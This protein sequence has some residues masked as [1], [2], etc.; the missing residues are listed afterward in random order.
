MDKFYTYLWLREDGTPYYVG[1]GKGKRAYNPENPKVKPPEN[2]ER[3]IIKYWKSEEESFDAEKDLILKYG[4][5]DL[6]TGC[7][8]N[9][10]YGGEGKSGWRVNI[11]GMEDVPVVLKTQEDLYRVMQC[12]VKVLLH[13]YGIFDLEVDE[14]ANDLFLKWLETGGKPKGRRRSKVNGKKTKPSIVL[15]LPI[16]KGMAYYIIR[17]D[18]KNYLDSVMRKKKEI[19]SFWIDEADFGSYSL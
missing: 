11:S 15:E 5:L 7:L 14:V 12:T 4:R 9:R 10:T 6:G 17:N 2:K 8:E 16:R 18:V 3:I 19:T 13:R 1:K